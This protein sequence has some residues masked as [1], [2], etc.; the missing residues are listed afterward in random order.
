M[1]EDKEEDE[2]KIS[3][4]VSY[5]LITTKIYLLNFIFD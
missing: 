3:P 2:A 4:E 5:T 1:A